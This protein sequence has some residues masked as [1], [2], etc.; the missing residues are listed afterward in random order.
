V[1]LAACSR[2]LELQADLRKLTAPEHL[3]K[4]RQQGQP[5]ASVLVKLLQQQQQQLVALQL[6]LHQQVLHLA[7]MQGCGFWRTM[8]LS[9]KQ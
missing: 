7:A 8:L 1:A 2:C 6:Q 3:L 4:H 5:A 9:C